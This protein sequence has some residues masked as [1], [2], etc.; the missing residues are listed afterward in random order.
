MSTAE[1]A[2]TELTDTSDMVVV[3]RVF[4]RELAA[5][6]DLV[7]GVE[8]GDDGR[9]RI[10]A[11]HIDLI[12]TGLHIHHTGEDIG[13]WPLLE[14]RAHAPELVG[15]ME[16]QHEGIATAVRVAAMQV[17]AWPSQ[18]DD[19]AGDQLATTLDGLHTAVVE[20]LDLEEAEVLPL[21]ARHLTTEEWK[22]IGAHGRDEM[23]KAQLPL[24][25]GAILE[26]A[27]PDERAKIFAEV[28]APIRV[29]LKTVGARKYR[30]YIAAVRAQR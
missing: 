26:D 8:A 11:D 13:L 21:A 16:A 20:H 27:D 18:P 30:R 4:R 5:L 22:A 19:A 24:M 3:H 25:F 12:L 28:P 6:P 2:T 9:T 23:T 17:Q 7:R 15:L 29:L 1:A 10:V 14:Q